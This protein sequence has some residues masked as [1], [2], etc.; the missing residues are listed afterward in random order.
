MKLP[1]DMEYIVI[2]D[3]HGCIDELKTLLA[4]QGF[5]PNR[6]GLLQITPENQDKSIILLGDFIEG[7]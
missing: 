6:E 2:G 1:L 5:F 7:K 3:V 4:K